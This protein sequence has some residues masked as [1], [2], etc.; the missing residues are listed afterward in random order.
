MQN[1]NNRG[2]LFTIEKGIDMFI[3]FGS[4]YIAYVFSVLIFGEQT[5]SLQSIKVMFLVF[6]VVLFQTFAF[7]SFRIYKPIPFAKTF[8]LLMRILE[9]NLVFYAAV[10]LIIFI[11]APDAQQGFML[12]W[13]LIAF[14]VSTAILVFKKRILICVVALLRKRHYHLR[15]VVIVGDNTATAADFVKQVGLNPQYGIMIVGYVGDKIGNVVGCE[16]LGG[17]GDLE[18]ILDE[19]RPHEVV[20]AIDS[21]NKKK[22]IGLVNMCDDRCIKVYFLPVIYGFFKSARQLSS[23]GTLPV[24]NVHSTPLDSPANAFFKRCLDIVG[25]LI[26]IVLTS[27]IMLVAAIGVKLSSPGPIFF[28]QER[29]GK[30]GK[31][32]T[33]LKFRSMRVNVASDKTWTTDNDPRK[34]RFGNFMRKTSIDEL[35]QLFNVLVGSMSLVGP[36]PEIPHFVEYF[37]DI[38]PLYMVKHYVK[39]GLTGLAQVRGLRGDTSVEERILADI[40]YIEN[41]SFLRDIAILLQT[42]FKAINKNER[43]VKNEMARGI[44]TSATESDE[45][46]A[47]QIAAKEA[48]KHHPLRRYARGVDVQPDNEV[49]DSDR[50]GKILY[51]ASTMS[52]INNFHLEYIAA[53][54]A[55]GYVVKTMAR[56]VGADFD[57]PFEKKLL[58][59]ANTACRSEIKRILTEEKFD[60]VILNTTL[61]A[62]HIRYAMPKKARPRVVNIVHGYLFSRHTGFVRRNLMLFCERLVAKKTDAIIVMNEEDKN[63]AN[64]RKLCREKVYFT[65]GMGAEIAPP[66]TTPAEIRKEQGAEGKFVMA[67]VGELSERKNQAFLIST[68]PEIRHRIPGAVLWLIGEG[69]EKDTE[70]LG[71]LALSLELGD[72]V[73]FL[74]RKDKPEDY[75]RA[76]DVYVSASRIEGMPFNIIEAMGCGCTTVATRIK[77]HED[78]IIHGK[79]GYLY[80]Y[81]DRRRFVDL[82]EKVYSGEGTVAPAETVA[83]YNEYSFENVFAPTLATIKESIEK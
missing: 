67:F 82:V 9:A 24:I 22:I 17:F 83:V 65:R 38:I 57:V 81:G 79:T 8:S 56:G 76:C 20:F 12:V 54:R 63:I 52:H 62:F 36:R 19:Y 13:F 45:A 72:A 7:V 43:Y 3:N 1:D 11:F 10:E 61:A 28:K 42:P 41:W 48:S 53:L 68:M 80:E 69:S 35:P 49:R 33:M 32:F 74:G 73:R 70:L 6:A 37:K 31:P 59:P 64:W 25:S 47:Q 66:A 75:M 30:L 29:V 55:D 46:L 58:T 16:K 51:A 4:I 23:I 27:P 34:T 50:K 21:Y 40:E 60:I 77:G 14:G 5:V 2:F 18:R 15:R 44:D 78:L 71:N 26:L 39:P